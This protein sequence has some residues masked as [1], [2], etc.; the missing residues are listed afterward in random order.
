MY[1]PVSGAGIIVMPPP[2]YEEPMDADIDIDLEP[3]AIK[4]PNKQGITA[5]DFFDNSDD[6]WYDDAP[7][8]F[9]LNVSS[10][11]CYWTNSC[12]R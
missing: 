1:Y 12:I 3:A 2:M 5:S 10:S 9:S 4:W 8:G 11:I 6:S 7:E